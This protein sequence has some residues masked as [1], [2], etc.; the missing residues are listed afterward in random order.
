MQTPGVTRASR[1]TSSRYN[2]RRSLPRLAWTV[3]I[4]DAKSLNLWEPPLTEYS[5]SLNMELGVLVRG[6]L[7]PEQTEAHLD[8]SE[9]PLAPLGRDPKRVI[10][11]RACL[12]ASEG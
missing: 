1:A 11:V 12:V 9:G 5:Y 8:R 6:G 3:V 10:G 7:L 4:L 2:H